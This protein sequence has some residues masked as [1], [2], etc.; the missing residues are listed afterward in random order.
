MSEPLYLIFQA[1]IREGQYAALLEVSKKLIAQTEQEKGAPL[2]E[3]F[4]SEDKKVV[5]VIERYADSDA[6]LEHMSNFSKSNGAELM[7]AVQD[8][9][10]QI[11]GNPTPELKAIAAEQGIALFAPIGGFNRLA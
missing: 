6:L 3:W 9:R 11:Y 8:A 7:Q 1:N 5:H 4:V 2:Y 10:I